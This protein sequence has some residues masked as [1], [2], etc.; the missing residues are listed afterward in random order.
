MNFFGTDGIRG[1]ANKHP[2]KPEVIVK[3]GRGIGLYFKKHHENHGRTKIIIGKDTRL[4]GYMIETAII[5]GLCSAGVN[6]YL[7]GPMPTPAVAHLVRSFA[8][9]A[10]IVISASH[11]P[12]QDN[13]IK[14]FDSKGYKLSEESEEEIES[15]IEA[16]EEV[17]GEDLGKAFR[18]DD[19]SGRYIE[20]A[21]SSIN[22]LSLKGLKIVVDCANG[23]AYSVAPKIFSELGAEVVVI[24]NKPNGKNIN[25]NCGALHPESLVK[26]VV[27]EKADV[28]I[29]LDGDA[30]R[31]IMVDENGKVLDGDD[32]LFMNALFLKNRDKL[33]GNVVVATVMSNF[34]FE[35]ALKE[36]GIDLIRVSVG[37]KH[38][39]MKMKEIGAS[40]GGEQSGHI[41]FTDYSTTGDGTITALQTLRVLKET[42]KKLSYFSNLIKKTPQILVNLKVNEKIP[43]GN[44]QRTKEMILKL[45]EKLDGRGRILVRYSGT[46][47]LLRVMVEGDDESLIKNFAE[48]IVEVADGEINKKS[49]VN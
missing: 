37:D 17:I 19:A 45:Q 13:G 21:K 46:Q 30:D 47:N 33:K 43:L 18:I 14:I 16:D 42:G 48:Q 4:S 8:A 27:E 3:I 10:G 40:I 34:G 25:K 24:H 38:V 49:N 29:A 32:I 39:A 31:V 7:V 44:L 12:F 23:A 41:I 15:L 6:A 9:D 1:L 26:K 5:S 20:F 2:L 22:N 36:H 11:N 35:K 28:G